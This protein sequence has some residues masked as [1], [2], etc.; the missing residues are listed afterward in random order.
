MDEASMLQIG[1]SRDLVDDALDPATLAVPQ[2]AP[3]PAPKFA[4]KCA[5]K[6]GQSVHLA[7]LHQQVISVGLHRHGCL[8]LNDALLCSHC[9]ILLTVRTLVRTTG[10]VVS[11]IFSASTVVLAK[12]GGW[13][14]SA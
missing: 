2:P 11:V 14:P 4:P 3:K 13:L 6:A 8:D 7:G 1:D 9:L 5:P 10:G 12:G